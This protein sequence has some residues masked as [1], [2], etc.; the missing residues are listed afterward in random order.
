MKRYV[1]CLPGSQPCGCRGDGARVM[2]MLRPTRLTAENG[3]AAQ[4]S[5]AGALALPLPVDAFGTQIPRQRHKSCSASQ[6]DTASVSAA[7]SAN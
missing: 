3:A 6:A 2:M 5:K 1:Q 7:V 4:V